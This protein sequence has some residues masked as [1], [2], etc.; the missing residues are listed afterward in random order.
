MNP[1]TFENDYRQRATT[2]IKKNYAASFKPHLKHNFRTGYSTLPSPPLLPPKYITLVRVQ[3]KTCYEAWKLV[4]TH[5]SRLLTRHDYHHNCCS[6]YTTIKVS[7]QSF[8]F[9]LFCINSA[10]LFI[11]P[12]C[13]MDRNLFIKKIYC[14]YFEKSLWNPLNNLVRHWI[15]ILK[16]PVAAAALRESVYGVLTSRVPRAN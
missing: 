15:S 11:I 16:M 1:N 6:K 13:Q 4:Y 3:K 7:K 14:S 8:A 9:S 5:V 2:L 10:F 12:R